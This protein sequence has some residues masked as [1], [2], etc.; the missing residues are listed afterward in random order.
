MV[1]LLKMMMRQQYIRGTRWFGDF[2]AAAAI[3]VVLP[4]YPPVLVSYV[5]GI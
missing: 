3:V 5:S 4:Y 1:G 2:A